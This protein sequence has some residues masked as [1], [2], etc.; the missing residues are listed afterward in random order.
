[1][2]LIEF[3]TALSNNSNKE[4]CFLFPNGK[5][6]EPEFHITEVGHVV[7]N[8]VDCGGTLRKRE[9]CLLQAWIDEH[10]SSHRLNAGKLSHI[11]QLSREIIS[12]DQLAI[13]LEYGRCRVSQFAVESYFASARVLTFQ[14]ANKKTDCLARGACEPT[15]E[16]SCGYAESQ[17]EPECC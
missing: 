17:T 7:K 9:S 11:L 2:K 3:K 8:F 16:P 4:L 13:E 6:I 15:S 5:S 12:S 1:M 14:L 10:D